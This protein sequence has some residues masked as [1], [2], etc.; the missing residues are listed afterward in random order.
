MNVTDKSLAYMITLSE[1][2]LL[3]CIMLLRTLR[4]L[5]DKRIV[6]VGNLESEQMIEFVKGYGVEYIDEDSLD[7]SGRLPEQPKQR[8]YREWGWY[9][10]MFIR[11]CID[12]FMDEEHI[13]VL[14]SEVFMFD[15]WD[16]NRLFNEEGAPRVLSWVPQNRKSD[17]DYLMYRGSA[18]VLQDFPGCEDIM[19]YANSDSFRRHINGIVFWSTSNVR[20][21]WEQMEEYGGTKRLTELFDHVPLAFADHVFYGLAAERGVFDNAQKPEI[22]DGILGWY[23]VHQDPV[24]DA[25]KENPMWSMCQSY[26]DYQDP[27]S[28]SNFMVSMCI[29]LK[30]KLSPLDYW[31]LE[32]ESLLDLSYAGERSIK[33]FEKYRSQLDFTE[34]KR[35]ETMYRALELIDD[36][37]KPVMVETGILRDPTIG[38]SHS[39]YKFGEYASRKNGRLH[40]CDISKE[41]VNFAQVASHQYSDNITYYCSDSVEF[42]DRFPDRIDFLYLDS[43]DSGPGQEEEASQHQLK[44]IQ[45]CFSKLSDHA[46][47]L[48]DDAGIPEGGKTR[49]SCKYLEENGFRLEKDSCQKLYVRA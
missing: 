34:N 7:M 45:A 16:E 39:T 32:D 31:T 47:V 8:K 12:R 26:F 36:C 35:F 20:A 25:F 44:E 43:F 48:L 28:Y 49:Y 14:D 15:N 27:V 40:S 19:E 30:Q 9:K 37:D 21:L 4:N 13:V 18:Y 17:W 6:V 41:A 38:G 33:Y 1:R 29:R 42:L 22:Y 11:L 24:F 3:P 23:D 5:T 10:Q 46:V 2:H